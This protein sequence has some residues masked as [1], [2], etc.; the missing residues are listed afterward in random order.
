MRQSNVAK[1][2]KYNILLLLLLQL[3]PTDEGSKLSDLKMCADP[4]CEGYLSRVKA[5]VDYTGRDCRFLT[6][7]S[8]DSIF[9]YFKLTGKRD[10]LWA[11][12]IGKQFG[13]FPKDAVQVEDVSVSTEMELPTKESDFFC[14]D[15]G[16]YNTES[17]ESDSVSDEYGENSF[18]KPEE[19]KATFGQEF[20]PNNYNQDYKG[21]SAKDKPVDNVVNLYNE[22]FQRTHQAADDTELEMTTGEEQVQPSLAT[23]AIVQI[24]E[25]L[26]P[27][28][29]LN[30]LSEESFSKHT[31]NNEF[32]LA[33]G[34]ES[35]YSE[36]SGTKSEHTGQEISEATAIISESNEASTFAQEE[37]SWIG[38]RISGWFSMESN[39]EKKVAEPS[40]QSLQLI[41]FKSRKIALDHS[42]DTAM[43][44]VIEELN[45][46]V[47]Y[48][49][50]ENPGSEK[51]SWIGGL[52]KWFSS[53]SDSSEDVLSANDDHKNKDKEEDV[54][55]YSIDDT[56]DS[57]K[58]MVTNSENKMFDL[59]DPDEL[60]LKSSNPE[61]TSKNTN[62]DTQMDNHRLSFDS[63]DKLWL[64][65]NNKVEHSVMSEGTENT[66]EGN[67]MYN[68]DS[69]TWWFHFDT[70]R[71]TFRFRENNV[72]QTFRTSEET[73]NVNGNEKD[74]TK[75]TDGS[76]SSSW[77]HFG[78]TET[79]DFDQHNEDQAATL[80][81]EPKE[82]IDDIKENIRDNHGSESQYFHFGLSDILTFGQNNDQTDPLENTKKSTTDDNEN[83]MNSE[84]EDSSSG[85]VINDAPSEGDALI[86]DSFINEEAIQYPELSLCTMENE[87]SCQSEGLQQ[88][89]KEHKEIRSENTELIVSTNGLKNSFRFNGITSKFQDVQKSKVQNLQEQNVMPD[90]KFMGHNKHLTQENV[91]EEQNLQEHLKFSS[92]MKKHSSG[93][94]RSMTYKNIH[95]GEKLQC[96]QE[97]LHNHDLISSVEEFSA[98]SK[99]EPLVQE[100]FYEE[101]QQLTSTSE[102]RRSVG[103]PSSE[104]SLLGV[105]DNAEP[106]VWD[107]SQVEE[108]LQQNS[109]SRL[110]SEQLVS[111][112]TDSMSLNALEN[113]EK[114]A[115]EHPVMKS[116]LQQVSNADIDQL[117]EE[118]LL[119]EQQMSQQQHVT[120]TMEFEQFDISDDDKPLSQAQSFIE[121]QH[122]NSEFDEL[123]IFGQVIP[124]SQDELENKEAIA[125][126]H[127]STSAKQQILDQFNPLSKQDKQE[128]FAEMGPS[129][130]IDKQITV[131]D[132]HDPSLQKQQFEQSLQPAS[133]RT[134]ALPQEKI[135][136]DRT[137]LQRQAPVLDSE[138]SQLTLDHGEAGLQEC[139]HGEGHV[140]KECRLLEPEPNRAAD[141]GKYLA[142]KKDDGQDLQDHQVTYASASNWLSVSS[143]SKYV[144]SEKLDVNEDIFQAN[145]LA[146]AQPEQHTD[147]VGDKLLL[148]EKMDDKDCASQ[149]QCITSDLTS[150]LFTT[151]ENV[152]SLLQDNLEDK[153]Q[154]LPDR[155]S[156]SQSEE[157]TVSN[158]G[159]TL[160]Q[161]NSLYQQK[162]LGDKRVTLESEKQSAVLI[163][164]E[165][166]SQEET[167]VT[168]VINTSINSTRSN[169]IHGSMENESPVELVNTLLSENVSLTGVYFGGDTDAK[170]ESQ[171][172]V[173][174][175]RRDGMNDN[176]RETHNII[177]EKAPQPSIDP[178]SASLW[179]VKTESDSGKLIVTSH[180]KKPGTNQLNTAAEPDPNA[181]TENIN[182]APSVN[183]E[184]KYKIGDATDKETEMA[185]DIESNDHQTGSASWGVDEAEDQFEKLRVKDA[186]FDSI[187]F[188]SNL[189][190]LRKHMSIAQLQYL[191]R[192]FE[193]T[194]LLWL[195]EILEYL[196]NE[197]CN[198]NILQK[199]NIF[200]ESFWQNK[201][202]NCD[203]NVANIEYGMTKKQ[204]FE[205]AEMLQKLDD[206]L[207]ATKLKC[208]SNVS[209]SSTIKGAFHSGDTLETDLA[210]NEQSSEILGKNG[211][212][213][214]DVQEQKGTKDIISE[215]TERQTLELPVLNLSDK[216]S[217]S[218]EAPAKALMESKL[219]NGSQ[220]DPDDTKAKTSHQEIEEKI[221][222]SALDKDS[223]EV[224]NSSV[225]VDSR[226]EVAA[227]NN[228]CEQN[229]KQ[230]ATHKVETS[231]NLDLQTIR[232]LIGHFIKN[233][234]NPFAVYWRIDDRKHE[235][236]K[237]MELYLQDGADHL[238]GA[239]PLWQFPALVICEVTPG[240]YMKCSYQESI[241]TTILI[242]NIFSPFKMNIPNKFNHVQHEQ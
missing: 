57:N 141:G 204:H 103:D 218:E 161:E 47:H 193:K 185:R 242:Q 180:D 18:S 168:N 121:Q 33:T 106:S 77:Y 123:P 51:S 46:G 93:Y 165:D 83:T 214:K 62:E 3:I 147:S 178:V 231:F 91:H 138:S 55:L 116:D 102:L 228:E 224:K 189:K 23:D 137:T 118:E 136:S 84:S 72:D 71:D 86:V 76:K 34:P 227:E 79:L 81:Q 158:D 145:V 171:Q 17:E 112:V 234:S 216:I 119:H 70:M 222:S 12:A 7:E 230:I 36:Y 233:V 129:S 56:T 15:G 65:Q 142:L 68:D 26:S 232:I 10:D 237:T 181:A 154:I 239:S 135:Y 29:H 117:P 160:T 109:V 45:N 110:G 134:R 200:E 187:N 20:N 164:T 203:K 177:T 25:F 241:T 163:T 31:D 80:Q 107:K 192:C 52:S 30:Q 188:Y 176:Y 11:G 37:T 74:Y 152:E 6:F 115:Q 169:R 124:S 28:D 21:N 223:D 40:D 172:I 2:A 196:E 64:H 143:P 191:E 198:N 217:D 59:S 226:V 38:S 132:T 190:F 94:G 140:S 130:L 67:T 155:L 4:E 149:K 238:R 99:D 100:H 236:L 179:K 235:G 54:K 60:E 229:G 19:M 151:T 221:I 98:I 122:F 27:A 207:T 166:L 69:K 205:D 97:I 184:N 131:P 114:F 120:S 150:E 24:N 213:S 73:Q 157:L 210:Y 156:S 85:H 183:T 89:A 194:K 8:G 174:E 146:L 240:K 16:D 5:T 66:G 108:T 159:K 167:N 111:N 170:I 212:M 75:A 173:E 105:E 9:V 220:K 44:E 209:S 153:E 87:F 39:L 197:N 48:E 49:G 113:K 126:G 219:G 96:E 78:L 104:T 125:Q 175:T 215:V 201:D 43:S 1:A 208:T 195:E 144:L 148:K 199:V 128:A 63:K 41:S 206:I 61:K 32:T 35:A 186:S 42:E 95:I 50:K 13:Y 14:L 127:Y 211:Q 90:S 182:G 92:E 22:Q 202:F 101:E 139:L 162:N 53:T 82:N 133:D 58:N 88:A 225:I